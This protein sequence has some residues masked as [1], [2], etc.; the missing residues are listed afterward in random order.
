MVLVVV[1]A[2]LALLDVEGNFF[3]VL[4]YKYTTILSAQL[5]NFWAIVVVVVV[6]ACVLGARYRLEQMLGVLICVCGMGVLLFL[7]AAPPPGPSTN[8]T[9]KATTSNV[10]SDGSHLRGDMLALLGS[11]FY[12]LANT[13]EEYLV[14]VS[15]S[16]S[17]S[18]TSSTSTR[19]ARPV[20]E[21]LGQLA[22][23]ATFINGFQALVTTTTTTAYNPLG[24]SPGPVWSLR[25]YGY[26][27]GY[28]LSLSLFYT[29]VPVMLRL[30]SAVGFN[31]SLLT[32]GG[33]AVLVGVVVFGMGPP[34]G[35]GGGSWDWGGYALAFG[36]IVIG[37]VV[38][39][40]GT[41]E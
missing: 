10:A 28:T 37:Q 16:A 35:G 7:D 19:R 27:A 13:A 15:V 2:I 3:L 26:I 14:S 21:V 25:V 9:P 39:Y 23:F 11:T 38:Y 1:D 12:G 18:S 8:G 29:L 22:F 30:S 31:L 40:L 5:I 6:S 41:G 20:Y 24:T 34:G 33:W 17:T 4:A 36:G 32:M